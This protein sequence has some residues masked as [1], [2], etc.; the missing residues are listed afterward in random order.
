MLDILSRGEVVSFACGAPDGKL[1]AV[2]DI[3]AA[4]SSC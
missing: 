4:L 3:R 2:G 1:F